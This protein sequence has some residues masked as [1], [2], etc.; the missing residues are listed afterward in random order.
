VV[1]VD[2]FPA[3]YRIPSY[4][5]LSDLERGRLLV[6]F[7][8][9]GGQGRR[10]GALDQPFPS[11]VAPGSS[12]WRSALWIGR[13]LFDERPSAVIVAGWDRPGY[14]IAWLLRPFLG[15]CLALWCESTSN[16]VR[17]PSRV[18][19]LI[20]R[21]LIDRVSGVIVPGR[22]AREYVETLGA[23]GVVVAP[24]AI[25]N[26]LLSPA[27]HLE[28][29]ACRAL[30]VGRL[31][32]EKDLRTLL[33]AWSHVE[34]LR[35]DA[36]LTI[37]GS[38]PDEATLRTLSGSLGLTGVHWVEYQPWSALP[39]LY[40]KATFL[41]A[42]SRSEPWGFAVNEA[43]AAGVP[44]IASNAVGAAHDLVRPGD[45]GWRFSAGDHEELAHI[46]LEAFGDLDGTAAK[47]R[48]GRELVR[49]E[50][51]PRIWAERVHDLVAS[52][53]EDGSS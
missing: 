21:V 52:C 41:V 44:V 32:P 36:E 48:H 3:P 34:E 16:D 14:V 42:P 33:I 39:E 9:P 53:G 38:G 50:F 46:M 24:N 45:T 4:A 35:P 30:F 20:K 10:W 7:L 29:G 8:A 27:G 5:A 51:T 12:A 26:D 43:L 6:L 37:V 19:T 40:S 2:E 49:A 17:R 28:A 1:L 22:A 23:V 13:K 18:K 15:Y 47:G 31:S 25:D 11:A